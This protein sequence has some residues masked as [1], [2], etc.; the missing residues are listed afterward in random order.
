MNDK[1]LKIIDDEITFG[2]NHQRAKDVIFWS[3]EFKHGYDSGYYDCLK[4][5]KKKLNDNRDE[6]VL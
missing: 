1:L 4:A 5:L 6:K 3:D 2:M